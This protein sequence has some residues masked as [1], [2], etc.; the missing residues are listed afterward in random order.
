VQRDAPAVA[1]NGLLGVGVLVEN[2]LHGPEP[3]AAEEPDFG[4][5]HAELILHPGPGDELGPRGVNTTKALGEPFVN[6][7]GQGVV[8]ER[9][10]GTAR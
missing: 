6:I 4:I 8:G 1:L 10:H 2:L 3:S 9:G 7:K 5:A